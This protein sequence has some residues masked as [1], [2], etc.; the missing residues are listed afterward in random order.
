MAG[1]DKRF[2]PLYVI[3]QLGQMGFGFGRL[4]LAHLTF[5]TSQ[6]DWFNFDRS[7]ASVSI[8]ELAR[9]RPA[10]LAGEPTMIAIEPKNR[11]RTSSTCGSLKKPETMLH[12]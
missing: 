3:E 10:Q 2:A 8:S 9:Y 1:N 5:L 4:H 7:I 6:F 12:P 11:A